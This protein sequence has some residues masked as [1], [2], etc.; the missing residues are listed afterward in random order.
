MSIFDF[1]DYKLYFRTYV[2]QLPGRGRGEFRRVADSL[3][4][5]S[6]MISQIFNG[7][8]H[9]SMELASDLAD[10]LHLSENESD[11][12]FLLVEF[13]RAG[14]F[15]LQAKLKRQIA[16]TQTRAKS[17]DTRLKYEKDLDDLSKA[18]FYSS[19]M[20]SGVR[21][22]AALPQ[23]QN[24]ADL[25]ARLNLPRT[26]VEKILDFLLKEKLVKKTADGFDVGPRSTHVGATSPFVT[27]HHQNWRLVGFNKMQPY[28]PANLFY[29][30]PMSLSEKVSDQIRAELLSFIERMSG[31]VGPS[32]S[33]VV[34]CL[35]IDWFEY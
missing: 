30:A 1:V 22:L 8:K 15:R 3:N 9:L 20:Y 35:N 17:L 6:T 12:L 27:K 19:W 11:Y 13:A 28:N 10:Y 2:S 4:V 33:E 31:W 32:D 16:Q 18:T 23:V 5:S 21:M 25:A 29:T 7:E 26:H 34:R 14:N 24:S